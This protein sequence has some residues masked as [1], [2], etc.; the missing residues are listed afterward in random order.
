MGEN[1][2]TW[3]CLHRNRNNTWVCFYFAHLEMGQ[4]SSRSLPCRKGN[5]SR[6]MPQCKPQN[7]DNSALRVRSTSQI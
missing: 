6:G 7:G 4:L 3:I 1:K 2:D 5:G